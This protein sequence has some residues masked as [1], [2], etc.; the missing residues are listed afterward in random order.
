MIENDRGEGVE[1]KNVDFGSSYG[2][3][4][5]YKKWSCEKDGDK[6]E[7]DWDRCDWNGKGMKVHVDSLLENKE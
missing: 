6:W 4:L 2:K 1:A 7:F 3:G 5:L